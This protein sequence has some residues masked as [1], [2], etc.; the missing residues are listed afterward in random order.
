MFFPEQPKRQA[1]R[2]EENGVVAGEGIID[3][4]IDQLVHVRKFSEGLVVGMDESCQL[5][6]N[7]C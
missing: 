7:L 3:R 4:F 2:E 6:Q 5:C 1:K